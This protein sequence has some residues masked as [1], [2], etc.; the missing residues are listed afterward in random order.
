MGHLFGE[1][2]LLLVAQALESAIESAPVPSDGGAGAGSEGRKRA[3]CPFQSERYRPGRGPRGHKGLPYPGSGWELRTRAYREG[4]V[5]LAKEP[6]RESPG[7]LK[8][9]A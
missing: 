6:E 2:P 4:R 3:S 1:K 8:F 5:S 7:E 9:V